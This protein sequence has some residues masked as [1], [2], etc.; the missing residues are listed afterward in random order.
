L[1]P[2]PKAEP[3]VQYVTALYDFAAQV[4]D[5]SFLRMWLTGWFGYNPFLFVFRVLC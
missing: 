3:P 5:E 4:G 2:K 1:K